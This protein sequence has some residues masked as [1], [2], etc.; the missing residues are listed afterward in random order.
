MELEDFTFLGDGNPQDGAGYQI[1][2][3]DSD[4]SPCSIFDLSPYEP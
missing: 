2:D 3:V 1:P 4:T